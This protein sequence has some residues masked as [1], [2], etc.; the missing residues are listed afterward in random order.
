MR[1][2]TD[3]VSHP[4]GGTSLSLVDHHK[5]AA[6][7]ITPPQL[8]LCSVFTLRICQH[9]TFYT[10]V[11]G[12]SASTKHRRLFYRLWAVGRIGVNGRELKGSRRSIEATKERWDEDSF[13]RSS[14]ASSAWVTRFGYSLVTMT[15]KSQSS[16]LA[17]EREI[18][19]R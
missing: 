4:L 3:K 13:L 12:I 18:M 19:T 9:V 5:N 16:R 11:A 8:T 1:S 10:P 2:P 15:I 7:K 14:N 6:C 17:E